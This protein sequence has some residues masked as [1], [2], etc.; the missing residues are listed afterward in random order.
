MKTMSKAIV[1]TIAACAMALPAVSPAF[2]SDSYDYARAGYGDRGYDRNNDRGYDRGAGF[3]DNR[4]NLAN[5]NQENF[6][7]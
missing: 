6:I 5:R 1:G 4:G 3:R 2:A 7:F